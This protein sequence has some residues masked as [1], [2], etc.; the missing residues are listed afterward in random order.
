[1]EVFLR[2]Q[3]SQ[4]RLCKKNLVPGK[5]HLKKRRPPGNL[6]LKTKV[7]VKMSNETVVTERSDGGHR[8]ED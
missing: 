7:T 8:E 6:S 5:L 3:R 4:R 2:R 1:M